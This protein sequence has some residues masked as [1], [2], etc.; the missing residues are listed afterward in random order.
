MTE[1]TPDW[2]EGRPLGR[3][4]ETPPPSPTYSQSKVDGEGSS[5]HPSHVLT[6]TSSKG[7]GEDVTIIGIES[8]STRKSLWEETVTVRVDSLPD[9][10]HRLCLWT[11]E[12]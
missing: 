7:P 9:G 10:P 3:K 1:G 4:R 2:G 11:G 6:E 8:L 12:R 5:G